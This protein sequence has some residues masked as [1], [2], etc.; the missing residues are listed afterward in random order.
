MSQH[1]VSPR[2]YVAVFLALL[3]FTFLTVAAA[4]V[5]LGEP[6]VG[7]VRVPLNVMVAVAIAVVKATL[8]VLYFMHVKYSGRLVQIVV[9]SAFVF[10]AILLVITL[11]DYWSRSWLGTPGS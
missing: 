9:A 6:E 8:V 4:R 1:I 2:V 7:G 5:D 10:L 3:V 11:S